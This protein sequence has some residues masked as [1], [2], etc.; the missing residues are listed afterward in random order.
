[1]IRRRRLVA[2][3][4]A[5][6]LLV[7]GFVTVVTGLFVTHTS[8][9]QEELRRLIQAQLASAVRGKVYL[10]SVSGGFLTGIQ[11]DSF[12]IRDADNDSLMLSTGRITA[13]YDPRDLIDKRL[14]LRDVDVAHPVI[15][16]RQHASG[17]WNV[18]EIFRGYEKKSN[19]P[20]APGRNFGDFIVIDSARVHEASV[21][22]QMPWTPDDTLRGA[23]LDSAVKF[24]L[25]RPDKEIR[26]VVD[27]G[28]RGYTRTWRWT[29]LSALVSHMRLADP[30]SDK[31]GRQWV[32]DSVS[33]LEGDPPFDFRN[34]RGSL[35]NLG[36][37]IWVDVTH[38]DLPASTGSGAGK[39]VWGSDLPVR[40]DI[41]V[42]GD[43]IALKDVAWVYPTL[44]T[45]G[46]GKAMLHIGNEP[47][48]LHVIDYKL[49]SMDVTSTSSHLIGDMTFAVG[50][51]V[52]VVKDV[53]MSGAPFD[54]D[55][56]R[57]LNG[58]PFPVDWRGQLYG[59]VRARG[60]PLN[61]FYVDESNVI[62]RDAHVRGATS[63]VGGHGELDILQPALTS[64]RNF[65]V[66]ATSVDLRSIEFLY[67]NFPR[68][69]GT[70]SGTAT[71]DSS[72]LDVRFA[73]ADI[74]HQDGPGEPSHLT[75]S[76][77]VTWGPKFMTYDIDAQAQPVSLGMLA[78]S[79]PKL[80]LTGVLSGPVK[81]KGTIEDL[82]LT[83]NL[84]GPAGALS[85]DGRIDIDPPNYGIHGTGQATGLAVHKL[86]DPARLEGPVK[87]VT[88]TGHYE[89]G[90][91]GDSLADLEG[92]AA[93]DL[94]RADV[95][96][97]RIFPS[98][99]HLRFADRQVFVDTLRVET[100]AA[101]ILAR[102]A[103]GLPHGVSDSLHYQLIVDSLGGFRRYL[104][105]RTPEDTA[106]TD[107]L[108]GQVTVNGTAHGRIDSL[109]LA[110]AVTGTGLLYGK[111]RGRV[112]GGRF[113]I[114]NILSDP[115]GTASLRFDTLT[116][117]GVVLDSA[118]ADV[119]LAGRSHATFAIGVR[120]DNGPTA[121]IVGT[122]AATGGALGA[123]QA[124][125]RLA[126]D[127]LGLT[128]GDDRWRLASGSHVTRDSLGLQ[129]DSLVLV[130]GA[131]GRIGVFGSAPQTAPVA[132]EVAADSIR[133]AD[134]GVL[135]Q[136]PAPLSG[137]A[138]AHGR[139]TG[140]RAAPDMR[141][142]AL[143]SHLTYGGMQLERAT[144][145]GAYRD[146]S[147]DVSVDLFRNNV[148]ALHATMGVPMILTLFDAQRLSAPIHGSIRADSA[149]LSVIEMLSS[150]LQKGS[151]RLTA[152]LEYSLSPTHKSINGLIA[153]RNGQLT[154]Q[155]LGITLRSIN[156]TVRFDGRSDTV[157]IDVSAASG[158][159][160]G[161][162]LALR[163]N[164][165]YAKWDEPRFN[166]ALYAHNFHV[167]ERRSL[168]SLD[169]STAADSLHLTG[170]MDA[171]ALTG[172]LRV[173]RGELYL[174]ERDI[175]R[176]QVVDLSSEG[177]FQ[178]VDTTDLRAR[179]I[180]PD[181]PSRLVEGLRLDDVHIVLGDEVWLRSREANIKLGGSLD[182]KS[183]EKQSSLSAS[184][185]NRSRGPDYGLALA[186]RL[187][188]DRGTY[189]LDLAPAPVQREFAVQNGTIT[190]FGSA[191][192][193]PQVDITA[194]HAVKRAGQPDLIIQV[195]LSGYLYPN[196]SIDLSSTNEP[197][198]STSDLVSYLVTGQPTY[199][200]NSGDLNV[201]QQVS[202]VIGPT[203]SSVAEAGLRQTGL[204]WF[205][206]ITI[207]SGTAPTTLQTGTSQQ[208]TIKDYFFGARLGGE[209]QLSNN[210]FFNFSAGLCSLN[211]EYV[212]TGQTALNNFVEA[213]GGHI[214]W[215]F[216]PRLSVQAGT[217]P[218]TSA[219]FCR[220]NYS[221]G[222][223][224]ATPRQW[225]LSVLRTWHF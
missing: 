131:G 68:L 202:N 46:G 104:A 114:R 133:L 25:S 95:D 142:D 219:L 169:V 180:V 187:T 201:V 147:L 207:Q 212:G 221:L 146:R 127:S 11:I 211:R 118:G 186:G 124:S 27:E 79:Y 13:S 20:K 173:D 103:L 14:L 15:F 163:G 80:P 121:R 111:N 69:G 170:S 60:G 117:A 75:G 81:A 215:R 220:T 53:R 72:W 188:A 34:I 92:T 193:N 77:R 32:F 3:V 29:K 205:D 128:I 6:A 190:F 108:G 196:P 21:I 83:T 143:L 40:Y 164:I 203:L 177:I 57:T 139:I 82:Q 96:G 134:V 9:G 35:R 43:S 44:P 174:P 47:S 22:L 198:L 45:T 100:T 125:T 145:T 105:S 89:V 56:L 167:I 181:A 71:L 155:N 88:V 195:H 17:R 41:S 140:T 113:D 144:A 165:G 62:F 66:N 217:D 136:L 10:G 175:L 162:R 210:L 141:F 23:K 2:L 168:A 102:G 184:P 154:A 50:F 159:A 156:G 206:V 218:P 153:V 225:G 19:G 8:Y 36:D 182:V 107:S 161:A 115:A 204:N 109:D 194:Q 91:R 189:T 171:A 106:L 70:I 223:V 122:A 209:K 137:F 16:I 110:G 197:Y 149:D 123:R 31:L 120:S 150:S 157:R 112:V 172:T 208:S 135:A 138:S 26:R 94:V 38:F 191:D 33:A 152:N 222:S 55:L 93:V 7:I 151:G 160:P 214:E 64:F 51:P 90:L 54:F 99:A 37:S 166:L 84:Q 39:I 199:A 65:A 213:L 192:Y 119:R 18:K 30:D 78:R 132:L 224:V 42:K 76:G 48:N 73:N 158:T 28:K 85:F 200:L 52:L 5:I 63:R 126:I 67:P 185:R 179:Q 101:T 129:I 178:I 98:T 59:S 130:N 24:T 116:V 4:S 49:T 61:R 216:N 1:M 183:A 148:A 74:V 97:L 12:A 86:L 87:P 58:K 176:K